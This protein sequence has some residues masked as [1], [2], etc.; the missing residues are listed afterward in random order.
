MSR[1]SI[2]CICALFGALSAFTQDLPPRTQIT[3]YLPDYE[4]IEAPILDG[5]L[6]DDAWT[7]SAQGTGPTSTLNNWWIQYQI[8]LDESEF[9]QPGV[10]EGT[11]PIDAN[12]LSFRVWTVYDD[13]Y[14]YVAVE[15]IDYDMVQRLAEGEEDGETWTED[16]VE[17]FI[18]GNNNGVEG[19]VN[20]HPEEYATGGQFVLTSGG[21]RRD[22]EAG[23]PSFGEGPDDEWYGSVYD[24][25]SFTG[26]NYEFRFKL[27]KIGNPVKGDTI[28]FNIAVNDA[29]DYSSGEADRQLRWVGLAHDESTYGD[30]YFGRREVTAPLIDSEIVLDG[31]MDEAAWASADTGWSNPFEGPSQPAV[32]PSSMEDLSFEFYVLH[33]ET[34]LY[35]AVDVTDSEV[36][37]DSEEPGSAEG[38]TWWDDSVEVFLDG[39]YSRAEGTNYGYGVGAQLVMTANAAQRGN[40]E[41]FFGES[42]D[43]DWYA[44]TQ[45]TDDGYLIEFRFVKESFFTPADTEIIGFNISINEDDN[46]EVEDDR[47]YQLMWNGPSHRERCYGALILGGP[48]VP[49]NAWELY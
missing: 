33:D 31:K 44:A 19:N 35:V 9:S 14:L 46:E 27:S 49:V 4:G 40:A 24:N 29:D 12:D 7:Y 15:V 32:Y 16:S 43:D 30:L 10:L 3:H 34:Y 2:F 48:P 28:G 38:N 23:D 20:D 41:L 42:E 18:D 39:D 22:K 36:V 1:I 11:E 37:T 8:D 25:D 45:N 17:I 26:F 21:A 13:E 5:I 47:D 6:D